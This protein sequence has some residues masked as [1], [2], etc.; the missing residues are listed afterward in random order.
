M[1]KTAHWTQW[2]I[3]AGFGVVLGACVIFAGRGESP[4]DFQYREFGSVPVADNGRIKPLDTFARGQL[5]VLNGRAT[6]EDEDGKTHSATRWYLDMMSTNVFKWQGPALRHKVFRIENMDVLSRLH[7]EQRIKEH[8]RYAISDFAHSIADV[9]AIQEEA[10]Q[11]AK[12]VPAKERSLYQAKLVELASHLNLWMAIATWHSPGVIPG[13][14]E[15]WASLGEAVEAA[16]AGGQ[17]DRDRLNPLA[18]HILDRVLGN[19]AEGDKATDRDKAADRFND[20]VKV[21]HDAFNAQMPAVTSTVRLEAY[22]NEL[23]PF[24][25]CAYAYGFIFVLAVLSWLGWFDTLNRGA[26]WSMVLVALLH[27]W[28]LGMRIYILQ[29]PPVI[30]L[31]SAAVF[32]GWGCVVTCLIFEYFYRNSIA[33]AVGAATG[34]MSLI[35]AHF[36]SLESSDT[37]EMMRAVLDTNFWLATHVTCVTFGY[38]AV[39]VAGCMGITYVAA[40]VVSALLARVADGGNGE[41]RRFLE[42]PE[43]RLGARG[44]FTRFFDTDASSEMGKMIY[45]VVCFGMFLSFTGTVLGGLWADYSWGRFWGW[46]PKEN[47]ALLI[48]IWCAL[49]LHARW[50]GMVKQRGM[51]LLAVLGNIVFSWSMFG[52]NLLGIGLHSYGFMEGAMWWLLVWAITMLTIVGIG[53][54]PLREWAKLS[55]PTPEGPPPGTAPAG[56]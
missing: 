40:M 10:R 24:I 27:T 6:F 28:A 36:L 13:H 56:A 30:N 34:G 21:Y 7:L 26:F 4:R 12:K 5:I 11:I 15:H 45:G 42:S 38:V 52:T 17:L 18:A 8:W 19:F 46:D 22:F 37:M 3:V 20:A 31:Y 2:L 54:L 53:L 1:L 41:L 25:V 33:L 43:S 14:G 48:V 44:F 23:A 32:I 16:M 29:R 47:G 51:A 9:K 39:F 49:I 50:G 55:P 35:V